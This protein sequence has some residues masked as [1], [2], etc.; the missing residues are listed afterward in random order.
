MIE[1]DIKKERVLVVCGTRPEAIKLIP[2]IKE[3]EASPDFDVHLCV[4]GQHREMLDQVLSFFD[5][6]PEYDLD[7]MSKNQDISDIFA[8]ALTGITPIIKELSPQWLI[9]Q[10][11]T[12]TAFAAAFAGYYN[13]VRVAHVEAGLRTGNIRSPWPEE[14]NRKLV[15]AITSLHFA[16]TEESKAN[17]LKEGIDESRIV[18][19][20]NTVIDALFLARETIDSNENIQSELEQ[21]FDYLDTQKKLILATN[22]RRES[23]GDGIANICKALRDLATSEDVEILFPVH[24]NPNVRKCVYDQL[25]SV[26][27]VHLVDPLDYSSFIYAMARSYFVI[28][29]SGGV[30]EEAPALGKPVLV[31]RSTT[32]RPD[33]VTLGCAKLV[34]ANSERI[35]EQAKLLLTDKDEHT[36]MSESGSLYGDGVASRRI[37]R[38]L[39]NGKESTNA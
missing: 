37:C 10:G 21:K 33:G 11:D 24:P 25:K 17:L 13:N 5:V 32:E 14:G 3:L 29:D 6:T 20:G 1:N 9:V 30:Q 7:L 19:T 15:A 23:F 22:H 12:S 34:G 39:L 4:T 38:A 2:L 31:T 16:P 35:L 28:S 27:N 36:R 18:V 26:P 8:L